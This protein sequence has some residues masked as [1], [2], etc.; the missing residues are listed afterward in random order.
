M[1]T[2]ELKEQVALFSLCSGA[3]CSREAVRLTISL[4]A[5]NQ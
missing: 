5:S 1:N 2:S 3:I 4:A